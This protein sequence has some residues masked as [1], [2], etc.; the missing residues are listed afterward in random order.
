MQFSG[1]MDKN[2]R[3]QECS[4]S[5]RV[6]IGRLSRRQQIQTAWRLFHIR[7]YLK[8][9][10]LSSLKL[11]PTEISQIL[12]FDQNFQQFMKCD[13][14]ICPKVCTMSPELSFAAASD[15]RTY[16]SAANALHALALYHGKPLP[17]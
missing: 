9:L 5:L 15:A 16:F 8:V 3:H 17:L 1:I 2:L 6:F 13:C 7:E 4:Y 14:A 11:V 10:A 12:V